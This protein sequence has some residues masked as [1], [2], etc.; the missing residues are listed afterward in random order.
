MSDNVLQ[1]AVGLLARREHS[2]QELAQKL[3]TKGFTADEVVNCLQRLSR[4]GLQSDERFTE[5][6]INA[7]LQRGQGPVRVRAELRQRGIDDNLIDSWLD[8]KDRCWFKRAQ[9]VRARKYSP[10]L[11]ED[12]REKMKQAR[13]LQQR[14][15]SQSHIQ[16]ALDDDVEAM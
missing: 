2:A 16:Y 3:K 7:R 11:P 9:E 13:F 8:E 1:T 12:Y 6:F 15:F 10:D 14:G 4:E 5:A